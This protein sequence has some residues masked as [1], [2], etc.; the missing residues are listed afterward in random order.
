M[1][2]PAVV[3]H[4]DAAYQQWLA[5]QKGPSSAP[6][7][8][9]DDAQYQAWLAK[10]SAPA[11][12][13]STLYNAANTA[14]NAL[15]PFGSKVNAGMDAVADV[16]RGRDSFTH[17]FNKNLDA[18][19]EGL[20]SFRANHPVA[21]GVAGG[22]GGA[23]QVLAA[24]PLA[25]AGE[26][27]SGLSL[28]ARTLAAARTGGALT[29]VNTLGGAPNTG[30]VVENA[31]RAA[32]GGV[33]GA[34]L[35]AAMVPAS[36]LVATGFRR[37]A[38][39][40]SSAMERFFPSSEVSAPNATAVTPRAAAIAGAPNTPAATPPPEMDR[41]SSMLIRRLQRAGLTPQEAM[42]R[43]EQIPADKPA[44]VM[45][46]AGETSHPVRQLGKWVARTPSAG[47]GQLRAAIA[48]RSTP[49][50]NAQRV[51]GDVSE[52]MG[53]D[54]INTVDQAAALT[55]QRSAEAA[56]HYAQ[57]ASDA[58]IPIDASTE[59]TGPKVTLGDLFKRPAMRSAL[60]YHNEVQAEKGL[61]A[62]E[63]PETKQ[64][65]TFPPKPPDFRDQA[66][67]EDAVRGMRVRGIPIPGDHGPPPHPGVSTTALQSLKWHLDEMIGFAENNGRLP[68]GS[69]A[70]TAKMRAIN[71]TRVA[72]N[73]IGVQHS[74]GYAAGNESFAG[75][76][77][78]IDAAKQGRKFLS[79]PIDEF[80][81][82]YEAMTPG[83]QEQHN[84]AAVSGPVRDRIFNTMAVDRAK[85]LSNPDIQERLQAVVPPSRLATLG[86]KS[87]IEHQIALTNQ[88]LPGGSDTAENLNNDA[89]MNAGPA[90]SAISGLL[91][92]RPRRALTSLVRGVVNPAIDSWVHGV[93]ESTADAL[94]PKLSAGMRSRE[95]VMQMLDALSTQFDIAARRRGSLPYAGA[96]T[97]QLIG[98]RNDR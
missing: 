59:A 96:S 27:E 83:E 53:V 58:P 39:V 6:G 32:V 13:R 29:A 33:E 15:N 52:A 56:P 8:T 43:M 20:A 78:F 45:E 65:S 46:V 25:A 42:D 76:S 95:D 93:N 75:N 71:D 98:R 24:A 90:K 61:P 55:A 73:D 63:M 97:A 38:P 5:S 22:V 18:E 49:L 47:A 60:K 50:P 19:N 64:A 74:P 16:V 68:D 79:A 89:D 12:P 48:E 14:L 77:A 86:K 57:M 31:K 10:Q 87:A 66:Q 54:R 35:G 4:D 44:S 80:T 2:G 3:T 11:A 7:P 37:A 28:G 67:W 72:L 70:T 40:V 84:V 92:G 23:A 51:L 1:T 88:Q 69:A 91:T 9:H 30:G 34:A 94:A 62:L 41:A 36:Q 17:S 21:A 85:I 82:N 26:I 81:R